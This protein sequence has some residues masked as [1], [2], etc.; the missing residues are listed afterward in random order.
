MKQSNLPESMTPACPYCS[1]TSVVFKERAR[2]WECL[3]CETRFFGT[4]QPSEVNAPVSETIV[5]DEAK[6]RGRVFLSYGHDAV[7]T[8]LVRQIKKDLEALGW[9]PWLD[10][11]EIRFNDDWRERITDGIYHSQHVLAFL[12]K[13]STRKPGVCR[14][15]IAIALGPKKGHVYTVLL[16]SPQEVNPPQI[17]SHLQWLDMQEWVSKQQSDPEAAQKLYQAKFQQIVEVLERNEPFDGDIKALRDWLEPWDGTV[18][19][20]AAEQGFVGRRWLLDGVVQPPWS[21]PYD[22]PEEA[23]P[24]GEIE[25]WRAS[26]GGSRVFWISAGPGWGKSAVAAR[27]AHAARSHVLAVHFCR[28]DEPKTR[29]AHTVVRTIAFQMAT[30]LSAYRVSLVQLLKQGLSLHELN[31]KELFTRLLGNLLTATIEGDSDKEGRRFIVLDAL[32]E[33]LEN[34]HS[35]LVELISTEFEK[36]PSWLGL[37]VTSRPEWTVTR[38]LEFFGQK[39]QLESDPRNQEDLREYTRNWLKTL[40]LGTSEQKRALQEVE[41]A[42]AGMFLYLR[43]LQDAVNNGVIDARRLTESENL[44]TGLWA[45]YELWFKRKFSDIAA[46]RQFQRPLLQ[47][48]L[49]AREPLPVPLCDA[50]LGEDWRIDVLEPIVS[51]CREEDGCL[52]FFHKSLRDWLVDPMAPGKFHASAAKGNEQ[53]ASRLW[54]ALTE[55][56]ATGS[57]ATDYAG[58]R[59]LGKAG[60]HY[61]LRHLPMH[62]QAAGMLSERTQSLTNFS[63]A[64][65]RCRLG[66]VEYFISDYRE[67]RGQN[68]E[69]PLVSWAEC[70]ARKSH[71]LRRRTGQWTADRTLLQVAVEDADQSAITQAAEAWVEAGNCDWVWLRRSDRPSKA[72]FSQILQTIELSET[73]SILNQDGPSKASIGQI[74]A[75]DVNWLSQI[76]AAGHADGTISITSLVDGG[77][78]LLK[79]DKK[80][81]SVSSLSFSANGSVLAIGY[82]CGVMRI[83]ELRTKTLHKEID[84]REARIRA[85]S[86]LPDD[87][88]LVG[89]DDGTIR[90]SGPDGTFDASFAAHST[91]IRCIANGRVGGG[92]ATISEDGSI[93]LWSGPDF[94]HQRLLY[95]TACRRGLSVSLSDDGS[96]CCAGFSDGTLMIWSGIGTQD[97]KTIEISGAHIG[98]IYGIALSADGQ[99]LFTS[100]Q[101]KFVHSWSVS[102]GERT[103]RLVG[104][105]FHVVALGVD[106]AGR[107]AVSASLDGKLIHWNLERAVE[108]LSLGSLGAEVT[109]ILVSNGA[110]DDAPVVIGHI[111]GSMRL[112]RRMN[113]DQMQDS[114]WHVHPNKPIWKLVQLPETSLIVSAGWDGIVKVT[115]IQT[116]VSRAPWSDECRLTPVRS[117]LTT[118]KSLPK[119]C[120]GTLSPDGRWLVTSAGRGFTLRVNDLQNGTTGLLLSDS[121]RLL[122]SEASDK[123][124]GADAHAACI[125]AVAFEIDSKFIRAAD[126]AG[127][128]RRWNLLTLEE[129]ADA[130]INHYLAC[131][132]RDLVDNRGRAAVHVLAILADSNLLACGGLAGSITLWCLR[133]GK[134]IGTLKG[135]SR[136]VN[137]LAAINGGRALVSAGWDNILRIWDVALRKEIVVYHTDRMSKA[138]CVEDGREFL[139]G[140]TIGEVFSLRTQGRAH[141]V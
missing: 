123:N 42:S 60:E 103:G 71:L 75:M 64:M 9:E 125:R 84:W 94:A 10:E 114:V 96:S 17:I 24:A 31:A 29:D 132:E 121:G 139:V 137:F 65:R 117:R 119:Y 76:V 63:F 51:F 126:E 22:D 93:F 97:E 2:Q 50:L 59:V 68:L 131:K 134:C 101:D 48:L 111:D 136:G 138:F 33:T 25:R 18:H 66:A 107:Q 47:L 98:S 135:H 1:T 6:P 57:R 69:A 124:S 36:L 32:D 81:G 87:R 112:L 110:N 141:H 40:E 45:L 13:H 78:F 115:D 113:L 38:Q 74:K 52:S 55:W 39:R 102:T 88:L 34:N 133:S 21:H 86:R 122:Q 109:S 3:T 44:P 82:L 46:Y 116:G 127:E 130:R 128:V 28:H 20:V 70:I 26:L 72:T 15:E 16:E 91:V 105:A 85:M 12:S 27:L 30:Q 106:S 8:P 14:Q 108:G 54:Q 140:T 7:S 80:F 49:A 77:T 4:G 95:E 89:F 5:S 90:I 19:Q 118:N 62:L 11:S 92:I 23:S 35:A 53:L 100:G 41:R 83:Y 104:H 43:K 99:K 67:E 129:D 61:A 37:V 58:W 79:F 73:Q 120:V 56:K